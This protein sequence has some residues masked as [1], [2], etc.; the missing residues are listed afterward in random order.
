M[1]GGGGEG[2][3]LA[4]PRA[5]LGLRPRHGRAARSGALGRKLSEISQYGSIRSRISRSATKARNCV[6][7]LEKKGRFTTRKIY[8]LSLLNVVTG[9][10]LSM[11]GA[12]RGPLLPL[13]GPVRGGRWGALLRGAWRVHP[14]WSAACCHV[15]VRSAVQSVCVLS[16]RGVWCNRGTALYRIARCAPP[17]WARVAQPSCRRGPARPTRHGPTTAQTRPPQICRRS[18]HPCGP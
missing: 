10:V 11:L 4:G 12:V 16:V 13:S 6:R 17:R 2:G 7:F 8:K 1:G 9:C 15:P 3:G 5:G 18:A 14:G